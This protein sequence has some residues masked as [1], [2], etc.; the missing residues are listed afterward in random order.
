MDLR[1]RKEDWGSYPL[2]GRNWSMCVIELG[3][4][5]LSIGM[6]RFWIYDTCGNI[7]FLSMVFVRSDRKYML[8]C[9]TFEVLQ[10]HK[11]YDM[12]PR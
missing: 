10:Q 5:D 3:R 7:L 6:Y 2:G 4:I 11:I 8:L 9:D 12:N 1:N